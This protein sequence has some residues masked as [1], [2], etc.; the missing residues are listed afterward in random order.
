MEAI[1]DLIM[2]DPVYDSEGKFVRRN[3]GI[4]NFIII[5]AIIYGLYSLKGKMAV[6]SGKSKL[7]GGEG[8]YDKFDKMMTKLTKAFKLMVAVAAVFVSAAVWGLSFGGET[9]VIV[10]ISIVI[11]ILIIVALCYALSY[12]Y[13]KYR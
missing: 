7:R 4:K 3:F 13:E 6:K 10:A 9:G 5:L 8:L 12:A 11:G 2:G 1:V